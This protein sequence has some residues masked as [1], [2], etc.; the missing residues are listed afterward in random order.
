LGQPRQWLRAQ[1][2]RQLAAI[3][4]GVAG[5]NS[6]TDR[7]LGS[8]ASG[9]NQ[10]DTYLAFTNNTG[11]SITQFTLTYDGEQWRLGGASTA[12]NVLTLQ[13]SVTGLSGS[14]VGL[15]SAFNFSSPITSGSA[16][17]ALDGN[18]AANRVSGIGGTYTPSAQIANGGSFYLR[19]ADPDDGGSDNAMA[20]DNVSIS[21]TTAVPEP[22]TWLL[23]TLGIG[24]LGFTQRG[25]LRKSLKY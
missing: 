14:W 10:F 9:N 23:L 24:I 11:F 13:Y 19:W 18:A 21:F 1:A 3:I 16:G 12:V 7:A 6:V 20:I 15:G 25:K 2:P 17:A 8:L 22:A 5:T 4:I